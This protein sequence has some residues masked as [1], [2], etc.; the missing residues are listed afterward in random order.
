MTIRVGLLGLGEVAQLMHLP[1]LADD[2]RFE[3]AAVTDISPSLTA[4]M[5]ERYGAKGVDGAGDIFSDP[6]IDAVFI[7][8]PDH[9]HPDLIIAGIDAQK[10]LFV[11]KPVCLSLGQFRAVQDA[12][13]RHTKAVFVGYMRRYARPFLALKDR[14]PDPSAIRHVR[15]RD[16]I[17][18]SKFFVDQTRNLFKPTDISPQAIAE[19]KART[20]A[21]L[22]EAIGGD[23]PTDVMRAYQVL[24]GLAS[25]SFSAMRELLGMPR[26]VVAARQHRGETVMVMFDYGY[27]T[28]LYEAV[29]SDVARFDSGIEVLTNTQHF[30]MNYDTPYIRN[31]PTTLRITT[32]TDTETGTQILGPYYEDPFRIE[33]DAFHQSITTGA[34]P[35]TSLNDSRHDLDLFAQVGRAFR[36]HENRD[37]SAA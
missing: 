16:I 36:A 7:L 33:L 28:A 26:G 8:T 4:A 20:A 2:S 5:A 15:I 11:E 6:S 12:Y 18:E 22:R 1:L 34:T 13:Q 21:Q 35:K 17:R 3:I 19:G 25:H 9:L 10:H 31:L 14:L 27:F 37:V 29:I 23:A 24:T 30:A 32:S